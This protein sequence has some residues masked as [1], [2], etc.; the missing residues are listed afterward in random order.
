MTLILSVPAV[1]GLSSPFSEMSYEAGNRFDDKSPGESTR[2]LHETNGGSS[3]TLSGNSQAIL[4]HSRFPSQ[5]CLRCAVGQLFKYVACVE[6]AD[7]T[8]HQDGAQS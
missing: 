7:L 8:Q 6:V 4:G 5:R 1:S 2:P 3:L